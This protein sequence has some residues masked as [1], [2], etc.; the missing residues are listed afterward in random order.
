M[1]TCPFVGCGEQIGDTAAD[2]SNHLHDK[3]DDAAH[4]NA[5]VLARL[6]ELVNTAIV[7]GEPAVFDG[8]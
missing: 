8:R 4:H 7:L 1:I 6:R 5:A 2:M 3:R